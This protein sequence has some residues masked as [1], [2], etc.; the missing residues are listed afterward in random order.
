VGHGVIAGRIRIGQELHGLEQ[1]V[2]GSI[3]DLQIAGGTIGHEDSVDVGAVYHRMSDADSLDAVHKFAGAKVVDFDGLMIF[4]DD[5]ETIVLQVGG[6]VVEM[7]LN[8]NH[9]RRG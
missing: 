1:F 3:E 9:A 7:V 6:K 5:E 2:G 4:R 8:A